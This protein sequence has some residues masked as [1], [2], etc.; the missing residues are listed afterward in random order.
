MSSKLRLPGLLML[1]FLTSCAST[2]RTK[3]LG[4]MFA[5]GIA[6]GAGGALASPSTDRPEGH[7]LLWAGIGTGVAAALGLYIFDEQSRS[8][9]LQRQN[10]VLKKSMAALNGGDSAPAQLLYETKA[11]FGKDVPA[12]YRNLVKPGSWSVYKLNQW[13][14]QGENTVIHQDKMIK[15]LPP[16]LNPNV[17]MEQ[18]KETPSEEQTINDADR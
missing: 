15:L 10:D 6:A 18:N 14:T 13:I 9:E 17:P 16:G 12:E 7:A 11:P 2:N 5:T 4:M 1:V 3:T 8:E